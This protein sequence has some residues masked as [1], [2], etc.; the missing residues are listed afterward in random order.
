MHFFEFKDDF[1]N[2][3]AS[4]VLYTTMLMRKKSAKKVILVEDFNL[5]H[6]NWSDGTA[7]STIDNKFLNGFAVWYNVYIVQLTIRVQFLISY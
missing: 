2:K 3:V 4:I 6:I 1:N 5:P 7:V